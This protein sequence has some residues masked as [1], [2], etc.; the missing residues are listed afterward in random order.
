MT[1]LSLK[2]GLVLCIL[3]ISVVQSDPY[4]SWNFIQFFD[5]DG[6][7]PLKSNNIES[8]LMT[9]IAYDTKTRFM[10]AGFPSQLLGSEVTIG[11][12]DTDKYPKGSTPIF[13][14]FPALLDNGL[15]VR[16]CLFDGM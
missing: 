7:T 14:P 10:C 4:Y 5:P 6:V 15:P 2:T 13:T 8:V 9:G 12:F 3:V 16:F 1:V 11:C